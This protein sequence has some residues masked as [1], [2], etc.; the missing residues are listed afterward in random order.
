MLKKNYLKRNSHFMWVNVVMTFLYLLHSREAS[1]SVGASEHYCNINNINYFNNHRVVNPILLRDGSA[2]NM[3]YVK[4]LFSHAF[5]FYCNTSK[6]NGAFWK[7]LSLQIMYVHLYFFYWHIT[8]ITVLR[9]GSGLLG[10]KN[11]IRSYFM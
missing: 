10:K 11:I 7:Q 2:L 3:T 5:H 4:E 1:V 9:C 6:V 8:S